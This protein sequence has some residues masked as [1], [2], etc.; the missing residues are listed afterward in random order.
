MISYD[1]TQQSASTQLVP[2]EN[3]DTMYHTNPSDDKDDEFNTLNQG[4]TLIAR[5]FSKFSNKKNNRLRTL[6]NT[7]NQAVV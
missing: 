4:L 6:S 7:R 2:Y 5:A 3:S 1:L